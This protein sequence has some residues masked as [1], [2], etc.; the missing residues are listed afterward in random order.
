[1]PPSEQ[2]ASYQRKAWW[3]SMG[4]ILGLHAPLD[5][6]AQTLASATLL[7]PLESISIVIVTIGSVLFI[8][9]RRVHNLFSFILFDNA[10]RS[11]GSSKID[12]RGQFLSSDFH[13]VNV[14]NKQ[15]C[16]SIS[17]V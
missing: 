7:A 13:L 15:P 11:S 5:S 14:T 2:R 16:L 4:R 12:A 9:V 8:G 17:P 10:Y 6:V 1:M 3:L